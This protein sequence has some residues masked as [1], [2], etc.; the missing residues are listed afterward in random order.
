MHFGLHVSISGGF[1]KVPQRAKE[2]GCDCFQIFVSN[3]RSWQKPESDKNNIT[4]FKNLC[5]DLELSPVV[6]HATYLI[7]LAAPEQEKYKKSFEHLLMQY[8]ISAELAAKYFV[9]HPG[10]HKGE[11]LAKGTK[12]IAAALNKVF[13]KIKNGPVLL[14][15]NTSGS[16]NCIGKTPKELADIAEQINNKDKIGV[17]IDTCHAFAAGYNIA[18]KN[19]F[20][21]LVSEYDNSIYPGCIKLIH[22]N[23]S[24]TELSSNKDRHTH[25]G[26]GHIGKEGFKN[27]LSYN[28]KLDLPVILETPTDKVRGNV[29]NLSEISALSHA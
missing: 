25:I 13:R 8:Q 29:E 21:K 26:L 20:R 19:G 22:A 9:L 3:P 16:G 1:A 12:K 5:S 7:N 28:R 18:E 27:I 11:G 10:S 17:C 24:K 4:E 15:E 2:E 23:D 14:L 6:V